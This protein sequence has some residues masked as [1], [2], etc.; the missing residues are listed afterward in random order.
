MAVGNPLGLDNTV[1]TGIVSALNRPVTPGD[2]G[3]G[4]D[5]VVTNAIQIDAAINPGNSG[6]PLFNSR[7][8]VIGIN[9]SIVTMSETGGSAGSI[10]LGFAIPSNQAANV[11]AQL[12]ESGV[13]KHPFLGVTGDDATV[14]VDGVTR[15]GAV[16][17]SVQQGT[18]AQAVGLKENDVIIAVDGQPVTGMVSLMAWIRSFNPDDKVVLTVVQGDKTV[19]LEVTLAAREDS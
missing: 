17:N 16:V 8:K 7:G 4:G 11:S 1:T 2:Q 12:I 18:P 10:G 13:A 5:V 9:S 3:G 19:D 14:T 6:G 15:A